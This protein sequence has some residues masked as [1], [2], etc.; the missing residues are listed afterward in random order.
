MGRRLFCI[1]NL[2][3]LLCFST[4]TRAMTLAE[5]LERAGNHSPQ[6]KV[7][8][9]EEESAESQ[10][11]SADFGLSPSMTVDA[12][13]GEDK[14]SGLGKPASNNGM[15][16]TIESAVTMPFASGTTASLQVNHE[17]I[18]NSDFKGDLDAASWEARITQSFLRNGFGKSTTLRRESSQV[19]MTL[20]QA[21]VLQEK[22]QYLVSLEHAF[23][24]LVAS[25]K[26]LNIQKKN[27]DRRAALESWT[28][29]RMRRFA[30]EGQDLI[31]V[32]SI[33]SQGRMNLALAEDDIRAAQS[34]IRALMP[35]MMPETW[36]VNVS[37]LDL[38]RDI[39]KLVQSVEL[40]SV[41]DSPQSIDVLIS[42]LKAKQGAIEVGRTEDTNK[43]LLEGYVSYGSIGVEPTSIP[44]WS[45]ASRV[46]ESVARVGVSLSMDLAGDLKSERLTSS[47]MLAESLSYRASTLK[48]QSALA[49]SELK[50]R[51]EFLKEQIDAA[52]ELS[53]IQA[54][55]VAAERQRYEQGRTTTLQMTTFEV[56]SAESELKV[57]QLLAELRKI[58][59]TARQYVRS[60][61]GGAA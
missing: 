41:I 10:F 48:M 56:D 13:V 37:E 2:L 42:E 19:E 49:W 36:S 18:A 38:V 33:L 55:K 45:E 59:A 47:R 8:S 60:A 7:Y 35:E 12:S 58:E 51:I 6:S 53:K 61:A 9:L 44:A 15:T 27:Y 46:R 54:R 28:R 40:S 21:Y 11:K 25:R 23:W 1:I 30:A 4:T 24:D 20:K 52:R 16:T 32:Q 5:L 34:R 43:P 14:R 31:Q 22:S 26:Q 39:E 17:K 3:A 29:S 57:L 50:R